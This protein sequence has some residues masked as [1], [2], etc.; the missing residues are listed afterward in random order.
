MI[1]AISTTLELSLSLVVVV[2]SSPPV[3]TSV[4]VERPLLITLIFGG[5]TGGPKVGKPG[6]GKPPVGRPLLITLISGGFIG[7]KIIGVGN[8]P[9]KVFFALNDSD[10]IV[11]VDVEVDLEEEEEEEDVEVEDEVV[12]VV[13]FSSISLDSFSY[14]FLSS[15]P[16]GRIEID[17]LASISAASALILNSSMAV[18]TVLIFSVVSITILS[19]S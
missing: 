14:F 12:V 16:P 2:V 18:V 8:L 13:I 7:G 15:S 4:S 3:V 17:A 11:D 9:V 10:V 6:G 1:D 5:Y 19:T